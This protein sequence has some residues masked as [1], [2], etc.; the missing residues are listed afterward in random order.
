MREK[1]I[2]KQSKSNKRIQ[3]TISEKYE[4]Q[5]QIMKSKVSVNPVTS[6][7]FEGLQD[8]QS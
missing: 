7:G 1:G 4:S 3:K 8:Y 5:A 6:N 2:W